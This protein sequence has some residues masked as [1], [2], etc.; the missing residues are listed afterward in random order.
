MMDSDFDE[1]EICLKCTQRG[2][3]RCLCI[4]E[5]ALVKIVKGAVEA[6]ISSYEKK[7]QKKAGK[8]K[9]TTKTR[10]TTKTGKGSGEKDGTPEP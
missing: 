4:W 10:P 6:G 7:K 8:K 5:E 3:E 1:I 9:S 2:L